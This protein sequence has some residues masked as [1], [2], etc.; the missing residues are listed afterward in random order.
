MISP[1]Q[2]VALASLVTVA[3]FL[4][5]AASNQIFGEREVR[6]EDRSAVSTMYVPSHGLVFRGHDGRMIARLSSDASGGVF[7]LFDANEQPG[8]R[9]HS[10]P[11]GRSVDLTPPS[12]PQSVNHNTP[13]AGPTPLGATPRDLGF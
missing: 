5:G 2:F 1:K 4:G 6:A 3:G 9:I 8:A 11:G 7:E 13:F 10:T 12:Q